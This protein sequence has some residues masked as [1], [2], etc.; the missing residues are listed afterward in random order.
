VTGEA[1][2]NIRPRASEPAAIAP[3]TQKAVS[4]AVDQSLGVEPLK[5]DV[6]IRDQVTPKAQ[7]VS[8]SKIESSVIRSHD[9]DPQ[10]REFHV[11]TKTN[12]NITYVYGDVDPE[13]IKPFESGSKGKAWAE[14]KKGGSPLVA[15]IVNGERIPVRPVIRAEDMN[16]EGGSRVLRNPAPEDLTDQLRESLQQAL[17]RRTP[18]S[19]PAP[20][21]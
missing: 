2:G 14:F 9:Y 8:Q 6:S 21:R 12:P 3:V 10:S 7:P 15:K 17:S 4:S 5:P 18:K 13:Q 16:P 20:P 19:Q 11:T 1:L